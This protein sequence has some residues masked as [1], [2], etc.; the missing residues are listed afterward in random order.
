MPA[1]QPI[2]E[3]NK[4][5]DKRVVSERLSDIIPSAFRTGLS[6]VPGRSC[7]NKRDTDALSPLSTGGLK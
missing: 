1:A 7:Q 5:L 2:G 6:S 4:N 3:H